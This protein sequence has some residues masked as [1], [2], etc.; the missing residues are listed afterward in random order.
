[1]EENKVPKRKNIRLQGYDYSSNG[2]YFVTICTENKKHLFGKYNVG[3]IH[4]SPA[5]HMKNRCIELNSY[6]K[7]AEKYIVQLN[8]FYDNILFMKKALFLLLL[9]IFY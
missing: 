6:G 8:D 4:E 7:I 2:L 1:M 3:A 5:N 9:L